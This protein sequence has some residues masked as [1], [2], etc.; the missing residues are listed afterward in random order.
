M[1]WDGMGWDDCRWKRGWLER[2]ATRRVS[3]ETRGSREGAEREPRGVT[4]MVTNKIRGG[5]DMEKEKM[6][7]KEWLLMNACNGSN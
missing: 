4:M 7:C 1:G 3:D 6:L 2:N 5:R